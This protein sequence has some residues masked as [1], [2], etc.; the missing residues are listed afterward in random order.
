MCRSNVRNRKLKGSPFLS[1][2]RGQSLFGGSFTLNV[3]NWG[4]GGA[5]VISL[6][7]RGKLFIRVAT[8]RDLS[9]RMYTLL[10]FKVCVCVQLRP[11]TFWRM[12][13]VC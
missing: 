8:I 13:K 4:E 7:V 11:T 2:L 1:F 10:V 5:E 12:N 6:L 9:V 3:C